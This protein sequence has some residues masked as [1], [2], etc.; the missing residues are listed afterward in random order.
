MHIMDSVSFRLGLRNFGERFD[1]RISDYYPFE[2]Y[3][4]SIQDTQV[5]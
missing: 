2:A 1:Y 3:I 4:Q 5:K